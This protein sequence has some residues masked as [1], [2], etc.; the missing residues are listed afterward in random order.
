PWD[1][2]NQYSVNARALLFDDQNEFWVGSS[3]GLYKFNRKKDAFEPLFKK[4]EDGTHTR[5]QHLFIDKSSN[6]WVGT[7]IAGLYSSDLKPRK[8]NLVDKS[9]MSN[10]VIWSIFEDVDG[11]T[12]YATERGITVLNSQKN[13]S[14]FVLEN[15]DEP[16]ISKGDYVITLSGN[17]DK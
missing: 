14:S 2:E 15:T 8:F 13:K 5:V 12:W 10:P 9:L 4:N 7:E 17:K 6:L 1:E 11:Q 16:L 3:L